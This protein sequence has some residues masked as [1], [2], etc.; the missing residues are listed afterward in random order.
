GCSLDVTSTVGRG[1]SFTVGVPRSDNRTMLANE[2]GK[3]HPTAA[4]KGALVLVIDD[5]GA[6]ADATAMLLGTAGLDV[7]VANG[8]QHA[9]DRIVAK[10]RGP[11]L[12]ICDYHLGGRENGVDAIRLIRE[13][14]RPALPAI[15]V[16]GDT[17]AAIAKTVKGVDPC[18]VL[19]KPVDADELLDLS[20]QLLSS[21]HTSA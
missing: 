7:L 3:T 6:V 10:G 15:L 9:L 19:N 5:E 13:A 21:D 18:R 1:T 14:T 4:P 2:T 12:V 20:A 8:A 16:S 17:S 11:D